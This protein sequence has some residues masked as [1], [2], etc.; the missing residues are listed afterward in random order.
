[1]YNQ[2]NHAYLEFLKVREWHSEYRSVDNLLRHLA[3]KTRS[4]GSRIILLRNLHGFCLFSGKSPDELIEM[5]K[6]ETETLV[7][8]Y[9]DSFNDGSHSLN[10]VNSVLSHSVVFFIANGFRNGRALDVQRVYVP[11]R[12]R[13]A[14]EY[15]PIRS[16]IFE[17]A[18]CAGSLRDRAI[19][20]VIYS[21]G[22]RNSTL[23]ALTYGD[24]KHEL[25]NGVSNI[26]LPVYPE[27]KFGNCLAF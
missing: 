5:E 24:V 12:Y 25:A 17:M 18:D 19:V 20:L 21:S 3:R 13:K 22:L 2:Q 14:P 10:Y 27:M 1:M 8:R 7:Q 26:R 15:I 11:P 4:E 6:K 23:R 16:E 9:S